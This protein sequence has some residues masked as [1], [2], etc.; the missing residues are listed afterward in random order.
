M[1]KLPERS[2]TGVTWG[3]S[4]LLDNSGKKSEDF[5]LFLP[6]I[7]HTH[8][9]LITVCADEGG[10]WEAWK[11]GFVDLFFSTQLHDNIYLVNEL[12]GHTHT[13]K[14]IH[15]HT[16]HL[17]L[18]RLMIKALY[19]SPSHVRTRVKRHTLGLWYQGK[20]VKVSFKRFKSINEINSTRLY[21]KTSWTTSS[22]L[23]ITSLHCL[24]W[25]FRGCWLKQ[26][27]RWCCLRAEWI[28]KMEKN[29]ISFH[30]EHHGNARFL[31]F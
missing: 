22:P 3:H 29:V 5:V 21:S 17:R 1:E 11:L 19:H 12:S 7:K 9:E 4:D 26:R 20:R 14:H 30:F 6:S 28:R 8:T 15:T 24:L 27:L 18:W 16:S 25:H 13:L 31:R 10:Q 23:R 2:L